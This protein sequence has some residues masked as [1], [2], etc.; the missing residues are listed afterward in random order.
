MAVIKITSPRT[1]LPPVVKI[2]SKTFK[3]RK[4]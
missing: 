1:E 3:I 2:N 4:V